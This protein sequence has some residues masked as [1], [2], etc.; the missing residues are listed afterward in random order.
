MTWR[1]RSSWTCGRSWCCRRRFGARGPAGSKG[2]SPTRVA[3]SATGASGPRPAITPE[4]SGFVLAGGAAL[5]LRGDVDRTTRDLDFFTTS[6]DDVGRLL[7]AFESALRQAGLD[8]DRKRTGTGFVR[9]AVSDGQERTEVDLGTD[10]RVLPPE[11][12]P[13]G[14]MLSGEELAAD[15]LLALFSRA[16]ARDFV[17]V[18]TLAQRYGLEHMCALAARK[19]DGFRADVLA[20]RL[21]TIGRLPRDEFEVDDETLARLNEAVADWRDRLGPPATS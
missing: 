14:P 5:V 2:T 13:L 9:L 7:A 1:E 12:G 17:D 19:D 6:V 10:A 4:A 16:E 3:E 8:V 20:E 15:R 18:F 21:D 11:D